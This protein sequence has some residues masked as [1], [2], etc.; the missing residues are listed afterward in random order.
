MFLKKQPNAIIYGFDTNIV[1]AL[2]SRGIR[3]STTLPLSGVSQNKNWEKSFEIAKQLRSDSRELEKDSIFS[4]FIYS[5]SNECLWLFETA[6]NGEIIFC[7]ITKIHPAPHF[8]FFV[9]EPNCLVR[10]GP[11]PLNRPI[12]SIFMWV[13]KYLAKKV[14]AKVTTH[15]TKSLQSKGKTF[16]DRVGELFEL[17]NTY[18]DTISAKDFVDNRSKILL[19]S[20][21]MNLLELKNVYSY[22]GLR[23]VDILLLDQSFLRKKGAKNRKLRQDLLNTF[24]NKFSRNPRYTEKYS[25]IF[26]NRNLLKQLVVFFDE[27]ISALEFSQLLENY[28]DF[29]EY[30]LALFGHDGFIW[31]S[32]V[33]DTLNQRGMKTASLLHGGIG[34]RR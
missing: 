27:Y 25:Y 7:E 14:G 15:V 1:M 26:A 30:Q 19:F 34:Q 10:T 22:L 6:L 11:V 28:I 3:N 31:E 5:A 12:S 16:R 32:T 4:Q 2:R 9:K 20:G 29:D 24:L 21:S 23:G 33:C 8:H 17:P 18:K 13:I